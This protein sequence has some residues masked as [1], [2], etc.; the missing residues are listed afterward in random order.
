[1]PGRA[2]V[3]WPLQRQVCRGREGTALQL[4]LN[5]ENLELNYLGNLNTYCSIIMIVLYYFMLC[6][7]GAHALAVVLA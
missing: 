2:A 4:R 1:M 5:C 6:S 3:Q 7:H